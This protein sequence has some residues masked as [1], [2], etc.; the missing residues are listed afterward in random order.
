ME[1]YK[2]DK[3]LDITATRT[4]TQQEGVIEESR[5]S[6]SGRRTSITDAVFG[7]IQDGG[8]NYRNVRTSLS[9]LHSGVNSHVV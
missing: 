7:D 9:C 4:R 6:A 1:E 8:P 3:Y 5:F 2:E